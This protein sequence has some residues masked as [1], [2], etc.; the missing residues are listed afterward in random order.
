[1]TAYRIISAE[2]A[3]TPVSLACE[4][5]GVSRSGYYDWERRAPSDRAIPDAWLIEQIKQIDAENRGVY[6]WRRIRAELRIARGVRVSGKRVRRLMR[7]AGMSGLVRGKRG[8]TTIACPASASPDDLVA[9]HFRP[10]APNVLWVADVT[11][12]RTWEGW[13][14]WPPWTDPVH[15]SVDAVKDSKK[16]SEAAVKTIRALITTIQSLAELRNELGL[17]HGRVRPSPALTR[18]A[19]LAFNA[20]VAVCEFQLDMWHERRGDEAAV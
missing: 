11:Y 15:L 2:R 19:R 16:G 12:L 9:R 17:G 8:R 18:H 13:L 6:G 20:S 3:R 1:M 5:V 10:A 14:S 7:R 4:L